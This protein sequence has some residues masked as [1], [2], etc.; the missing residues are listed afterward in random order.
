MNQ[1]IYQPTNDGTNKP[2]IAPTS[3]RIHGPQAK[4]AV[5]NKNAKRHT[6]GAVSTGSISF[7]L[8]K[9]RT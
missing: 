3:Q 6:L 5:S 8:P 1:Y 2:M 9:A 4:Q 7:S